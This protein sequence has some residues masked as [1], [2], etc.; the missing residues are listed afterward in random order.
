MPSNA[1][2]HWTT[3]GNGA[4]RRHRQHRSDIQSI[5][6]TTGI[7]AVIRPISRQWQT[8]GRG[9]DKRV[10]PGRPA[11]EAPLEITDMVTTESAGSSVDSFIL[12][13]EL[14]LLVD[15]I[16]SPRSS[17]V[18]TCCNRLLVE[19]LEIRKT[20]SQSSCLLCFCTMGHLLVPRYHYLML[21]SKPS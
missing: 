10:E 8:D 1:G 15:H 7:S 4:G 9:R 3:Y 19:F 11:S 14:L 6:V 18:L 2:R 21:F 17:L 5:Y 13:C 16:C 20:R 12:V